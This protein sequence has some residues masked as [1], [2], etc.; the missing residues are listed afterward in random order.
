MRAFY[1]PKGLAA[2]AAAVVMSLA[3]RAEA[4]PLFELALY[5][6]SEYACNSSGCWTNYNI[7]ADLDNDGALDVIEVNYFGFFEQG[8]PQP[9]VI[10][11]NGG[12][13]NFLMVSETSIGGFSGRLRQ[14]AIADVTGDGFL[15]IYAPDGYG[16]QGG[17]PDA[18]F[19]NQGDGT[20]VDEADARLPGGQA[21]AGGARFGDLDGDGDMD[22]FVA[23]GYALGDSATTFGR[24]LMNDGSG[25]F[26]K[27]GS[28]PSG[29][30]GG[31]D[32]DDVDLL[33]FD[34]DFD[35][36]VLINM[37]EG[38]SLLWEN[39]GFGNF[40]DVGD[41]WVAQPAQG[42]HYNPAVCDVDGDGDLDVWTDDTAPGDQE[43]LA[44]NDGTGEFSDETAARVTGNMSGA[45]DHGVICVDVDG[46]DDFD[47]VV[48]N[49]K[50]DDPNKP[51]VE[52]VLYNDGSGNFVGSPLW[53]EFALANDFTLW[54]DAADLD[55]DGRLDFVTSEGDS[56]G[57]AAFYVGNDNVLPD[58]NPPKIL[59]VS[60]VADM[61]PIDAEPVVRFAVS[62][63]VVSDLG[64]R[65]SQAFV[66]VSVDEGPFG[67]YEAWFVGG[68]LFHAGLPPG[69]A[70]ATVEYRACASDRRGNEA[71]AEAL[72]YSI[73]ETDSTTTDEGGSTSGDEED[74]ADEIGE[75]T[76]ETGGLG[77]EAEDK[78]IAIFAC[79]E[80]QAAPPVNEERGYFGFL[81]LLGLGLWWRRRAGR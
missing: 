47:A 57:R 31:V 15:D 80:C 69:P 58:P 42:Y 32:P 5:P 66:R 70:G 64:P 14:I 71:C 76:D 1:V 63:E 9:L 29:S 19:I 60:Q 6:F 23:D 65:L 75:G 36:D 73:E 53:D 37:H 74:S 59:A 44:I 18:F 28:V 61:Q 27:G 34:R 13:G 17:F 12:D 2:L 3:T 78:C 20:F 49:L 50:A 54:G 79:C 26:S 8:M 67:D 48:F 39:D 35:L 33:D 46:D 56:A 22:I 24:I 25:V 55:G 77:P 81:G 7:L 41:R 21:F 62:D 40:T 72:F 51:Y 11:S 45:D 16:G 38:K 4:V 43:Q 30:S 68:D 10:Y 52:R